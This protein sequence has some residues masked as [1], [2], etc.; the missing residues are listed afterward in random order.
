MSAIEEDQQ[1]ME[2][3]DELEPLPY[4]PRDMTEDEFANLTLE[5]RKTHAKKVLN[6]KRDMFHPNLMLMHSNFLQSEFR[7]LSAK[8]EKG[9][10]YLTRMINQCGRIQNPGQQLVCL[11]QLDCK[12]ELAQ[13]TKCLI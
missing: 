1:L 9:F 6:L 2:E 8:S 4:E 13:Y 5:E 10:E 3:G 7:E 11:I 12:R